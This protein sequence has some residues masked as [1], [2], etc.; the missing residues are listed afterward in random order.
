MNDSQI[1]EKLKKKAEN[2][3]KSRLDAILENKF[4]NKKSNPIDDYFGE[5]KKEHGIEFTDPRVREYYSKGLWDLG[6]GFRIPALDYWIDDPDLYCAVEEVREYM[7][8]KQ[9]IPNSYYLV[10]EKYNVKAQGDKNPVTLIAH[11]VGKIGAELRKKII[12]EFSVEQDKQTSPR[13]TMTAKERWELFV[14]DIEEINDPLL[15]SFF[16]NP[17]DY[18]V[19]IVVEYPAKYKFFNELL[20]ATKDQWNP[21]WEKHFGNNGV[22]F[23]YEDR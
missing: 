22:E 3:R 8:T 11:H 20:T 6:K 12:K 10:A 14:Q 17:N 9:F 13:L 15:C 7:R 4:K 1:S 16:K 19:K 2:M 18:Y 5:I 21:I 23:V